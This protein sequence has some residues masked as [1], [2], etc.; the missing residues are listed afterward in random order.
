M[1][2]AVTLSK[3][4]GVLMLVQSATGLLFS[5]QYRASP[6]LLPRGSATIG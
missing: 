5:S 6:G 2:R 1:E 4:L 3:A